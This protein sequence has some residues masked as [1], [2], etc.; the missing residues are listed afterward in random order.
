[1][2]PGGPIFLSFGTN[3]TMLLQNAPQNSVVFVAVV[4]HPL[5]VADLVGGHLTDSTGAIQY[6]AFV[7][8]QQGS[9]SLTLDWDQIYQATHFQFTGQTQVGFVAEFFDTQGRK[10]TR[11][12]TLTLSCPGASWG[13]CG[14]SCTDLQN[15]R[16]N[17]GSCGT[18]CTFVSFS[19]TC[20]AGLCQDARIKDPSL[21]QS[22]QAVCAAHGGTCSS[23]CNITNVAGKPD[24]TQYMCSVQAYYYVDGACTD[25]PPSSDMGCP[26]TDHTCC[27]NAHP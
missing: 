6:G 21:S 13:T 24:Q 20:A 16:L 23:G 10:A 5:G 19:D 22:C 18:S 3:V 14:E 4:T 11:S 27:C 15:D 25:V 1:M 9:Y 8:S 26:P 17:C 2:D 12:T 7:A